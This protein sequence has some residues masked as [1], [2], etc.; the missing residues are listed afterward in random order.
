MPT[1]HFVPALHL[2]P[3]TAFE[4]TAQR[5]NHHGRSTIKR[6]A[7]HDPNSLNNGIFLLRVSQWAVIL[8]TA[9]IAYPHYNPDVHLRFSDQSAIEEFKDQ[10]QYVPQ[11]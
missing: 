2:A 5:R 1:D 4:A 9:I 8:F 10:V 7:T 11:H 3:K 6:I